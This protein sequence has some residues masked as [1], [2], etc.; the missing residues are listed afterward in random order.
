MKKKTIMRILAGTV[1][2]AALVI[3][4]MKGIEIYKDSVFYKTQRVNKVI[5]EVPKNEF[6]ELMYDEED[7]TVFIFAE[8]EEGIVDLATNSVVGLD[9]WQKL[10]GTMVDYNK[11]FL[12]YLELN[13]IEMV[14]VHTI[15][16]TGPAREEIAE[17]RN[18][19]EY[20]DSIESTMEIRDFYK[21]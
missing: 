20:S 2:G 15:I 12:E 1:I 18:G 6:M 17:I 14:D 16:T 10:K 5:K 7:N 21:N 19:K 3:G 8:T 11:E 9:A 4:T 13:E